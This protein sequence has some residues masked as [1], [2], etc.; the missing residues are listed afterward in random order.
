MP[1]GLVVAD[2][3]VNMTI[4]HTWAGDLEINLVAPDGTRVPLSVNNGGSTPTGQA[5]INTTFDDQAALAITAFN[6][7]PPF[8]GVFRPQGQLSQ[9]NGRAINGNWVLEVRDGAMR[10]DPAAE[11]AIRG[12]AELLAFKRRDLAGRGGRY[13]RHWNGSLWLAPA[14]GGAVRGRCYLHAYDGEPGGLP[15]L[16]QTGVY[17]DTIVRDGTVWRFAVR[18]L[19]L[20]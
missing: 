1:A 5:Y 6:A 3:N 18:R 7:N 17:E 2:L 14:D 13:R 9:F 10:R 15:A 12:R 11:F 8:T 20:D 16:A 19:T 4:N